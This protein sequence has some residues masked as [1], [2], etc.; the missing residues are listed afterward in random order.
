MKSTCT[1]VPLTCTSKKVNIHESATLI[2]PLK[3]E[4]HN[5]FCNVLLETLRIHLD[6]T[7]T[8]FLLNKV[9]V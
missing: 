5:I 7:I 9:G 1:L 2:K 4:K 6:V 3:D 8:H